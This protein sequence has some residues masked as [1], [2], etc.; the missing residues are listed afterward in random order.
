MK[1]KVAAVSTL[2]LYTQIREA[3]RTRILDGSYQT[4]AQLPTESELTGQFGV[5]RITVRQALNDLQKEGL[6]FKIHGKGAFVSKPKAFQDLARLQG[7][8]EAMHVH[9]YETYNKLI[10]IRHMAAPKAVA[11]MLKLGRG[12]R[13]TELRRVR[14]LNREPISLDVSY[15]SREIGERLAKEDLATRDIFLILEND[16]GIHLGN[17]ELRI[18]ATTADDQL[19][20]MLGISD[21]APIL[22]IERLTCTADG[23]PLDFEYLY[24]RGDAFQYRLR[25]ERGPAHS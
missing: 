15:L 4:H 7:F 10:S 9:G 21:G 22:R 11:E 2:P 5:S 19:A 8:A 12:A 3:L 1:R 6:I 25:V 16:Y 13:I 14:F 23:K 24:Y 20:E 18:E 17:A